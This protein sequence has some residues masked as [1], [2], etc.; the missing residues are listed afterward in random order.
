MENSLGGILKPTTETAENEKWD[1]M[2]SYEWKTG[3]E[4]AKDLYNILTENG[5]KVWF[6]EEN[7]AGNL[8]SE[9]AKGVANSEVILLLI[10]EE[11]E[12]SYNCTREYEHANSCRKIMIPIQVKNYLPPASTSLAVIIAGKIYY[13]LYEKKEENMK[14]IIKEIRRIRTR[15]SIKG[16]FKFL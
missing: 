3:K 13:Q 16:T 14:R 10:S 4:Y 12:K 5:Y 1:V 8:M 9:I 11:Y 2:V 6:D 7:V 15:S